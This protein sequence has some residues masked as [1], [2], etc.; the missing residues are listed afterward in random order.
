MVDLLNL[1]ELILWHSGKGHF[2]S[3]INR[4]KNSVVCKKMCCL[5]TFIINSWTTCFFHCFFFKA[6]QFYTLTR[7]ECLFIFYNNVITCFKCVACHIV[8]AS[9]T[10]VTW[11]DGARNTSLS[12]NMPAALPVSITSIGFVHNGELKT[13]TRWVGSR[14]VRLPYRFW[15]VNVGQLFF[16]LAR[17][18]AYY[19][20]SVLLVLLQRDRL[21][22]PTPSASRQSRN[23][24]RL[25]K[26]Q[27]RAVTR[28][29]EMN[30]MILPGWKTA[31]TTV[32]TTTG[33]QFE[34]KRYKCQN[35]VC[36]ELKCIWNAL[37]FFTCLALQQA[38]LTYRNLSLVLL[39][40]ECFNLKN[41]ISS[42]VFA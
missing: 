1:G 11:T 42:V 20:W 15:R 13:Q 26:P 39:H 6:P 36:I 35:V 33:G 23:A 22:P 8:L 18:Y 28:R 19:D 32:L 2:Y 24:P 25:A 4:Q 40:F 17:C 16:T 27:Q 12:V 9:V 5:I 10:N 38:C 3:I 14:P 31:K 29:L 41:C 21:L 37:V 7:S 34:E 30:G